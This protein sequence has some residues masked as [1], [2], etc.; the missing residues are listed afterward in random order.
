MP[1]LYNKSILSLRNNNTTFSFL[2]KMDVYPSPASSNIVMSPINNIGMKNTKVFNILNYQEN[3]LNL[4]NSLQ[5]KTEN[6][7]IYNSR[8]I[9]YSFD[10]KNNKLNL[11]FSTAEKLL[12]S[13][14]LS[15]SSLISKPVFLIYHDKIIIKL[16][17]Y[18]SPVE[19]KNFQT[20][21]LNKHLWPDINR[22]Q[23]LSLLSS[24]HIFTDD[25][26]HANKL[27][28]MWQDL[29]LLKEK[30]EKNENLI[31]T[32]RNNSEGNI[33]KI[34]FNLNKNKDTESR[35]K[36]FFNKNK[37]T[38][39]K[40]SFI[41]GRLFGKKVELNIIRLH[42]PFHDSTILSKILGSPNNSSKYKFSRMIQNLLPRAVIRNPSSL[43]KEK[44]DMINKNET[45]FLT[46]PNK[47]K[48]LISGLLPDSVSNLNFFEKKMDSLTL[49]ANT[50]NKLGINK[51]INKISTGFNLFL[52]PKNL[53]QT[54]SR[55]PSYT[56]GLSIRLGGRLLSQRIIP[57]YTVQFKQEGSLARGKVAFLETSRF[58]TKNKRGAYSFTINIS[59]VI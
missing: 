8:S 56:S 37:D 33:E 35:L 9:I 12:N 3:N 21:V 49:N 43:A 50:Y 11:L 20:S 23:E 22:I 32:S 38:L 5:K 13:F 16:L 44:L 59:H 26:D 48:I 25:I 14:F 24:N 28:E 30:K 40:F 54:S 58:T 27:N 46:S 55:L 2:K 36:S 42:F 51:P 47:L 41:L 53:F 34:K 7:S 19:D 52:D 29:S 1:N 31:L 6:Q 15:L 39:E 18:V 45:P 4:L 17:I 10:S 57:R